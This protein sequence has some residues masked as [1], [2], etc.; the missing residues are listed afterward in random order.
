MNEP[1]DGIAEE[2]ERQLQLGLAGAAIAA[3]RATAARQHQVEQAQRDSAQNAQ[4]VKALIDAERRLA[5]AHV[6]PVFDSGWWESATPGDVAD[7][8]QEANSWRDPDRDS[9]TTTIFDHAATR[10]DQELKDRTGL[11][12]T[13]IL[14]IATVQELEHED[15]TTSADP[16]QQSVQTEAAECDV[17]SPGGFDDPQRREQLRERLA[18]AGV[19]ETAIEAR[20][21]A[22]VGQG[23]EPAEAARTAVAT[24][25][26]PPRRAGWRNAQEQLQRRR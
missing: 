26:V 6:Q 3:R 10:I 17:P 8:W 15:Q 5:A 24:G 14:A 12:P 7:M 18:V 16:A 19:P 20:T 22:D 1:S 2:L 25:D 11:N 13:Q 23:R 21:L 9:A 4:A